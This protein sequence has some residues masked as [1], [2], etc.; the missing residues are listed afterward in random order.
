M[1]LLAARRFPLDS[2]FSYFWYRHI[3]RPLFNVAHVVGAIPGTR[4]RGALGINSLGRGEDRKKDGRERKKKKEK[5]K[6]R[7]RTR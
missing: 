5:T 4:A 6:N 2:G 3:P 1:F 7:R